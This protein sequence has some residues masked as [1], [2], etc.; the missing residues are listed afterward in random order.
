MRGPSSPT[1]R[2]RWITT[3][4]KRRSIASLAAL[5]RNPNGSIFSGNGT[6]AMLSLAPTNGRPTASTPTDPS[7]TGPSLRAAERRSTSS[8]RYLRANGGYYDASQDPDC[9]VVGG[10]AV[11]RDAAHVSTL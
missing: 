10:L 2:K 1:G 6:S 4:R 3:R 7:D 5:H 9:T 8:N 11:N